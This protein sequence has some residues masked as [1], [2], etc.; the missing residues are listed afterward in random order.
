MI[1]DAY[2]K[3]LAACERRTEYLRQLFINLLTLVRNIQQ[4]LNSLRSNG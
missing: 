2:W 4:S 1:S 3:R